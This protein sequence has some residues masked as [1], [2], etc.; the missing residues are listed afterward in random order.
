MTSLTKKDL[1]QALTRHGVTNLPPA[2]A[3]RDELVSLYERHIMAGSKSP[4]EAGDVDALDDDE[5]IKMLK[6]NDIAVG[7]I[8]ASTRDFYKKKLKLALRGESMDGSNGISDTEEKDVETEPVVKEEYVETEPKVEEEYM[9]TVPKVEE[10]YNGATSTEDLLGAADQY[11]LE[12]LKKKCEDKLCSSL[13]V[14]NSVED[15]VV[16][17]PVLALQITKALV[18]KVGMKRKRQNNN[19]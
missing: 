11:H 9:E 17:H 7:P 6:K 10:E 2:S 4:V 12:L 14:S 8:V 16:Q 3:R 5:L 1:R 13:E 19:D 18:Q 15:F